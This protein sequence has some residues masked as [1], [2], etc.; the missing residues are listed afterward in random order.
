MQRAMQETQNAASH[1]IST[2]S[3]VNTGFFIFSHFHQG[4]GFDK[5]Q[6]EISVVTALPSHLIESNHD[7]R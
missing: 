2:K 1:I 6:K 7:S 3:E 5:H 4:R